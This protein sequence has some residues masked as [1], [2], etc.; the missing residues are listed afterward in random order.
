MDQDRQYYQAIVYQKMTEEMQSVHLDMLRLQHELDATLADLEYHEFKEKHE[1][2]IR[3]KYPAV[4]EA[5]RN[6]RLLFKLALE[7]EK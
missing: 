7:S 2:S 5:Y 6:Y 4:G 1:E 3:S